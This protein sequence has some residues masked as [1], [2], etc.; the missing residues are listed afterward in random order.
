[1]LRASLS[2]DRCYS[3]K[4]RVQAQKSFFLYYLKVPLYE[5]SF[6]GLGHSEFP[7]VGHFGDYYEQARLTA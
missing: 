6:V 7:F 5:T 3:S 1:M 2:N 4:T